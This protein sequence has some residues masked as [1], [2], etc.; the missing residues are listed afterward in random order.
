MVGA[1]L[2]MS[3]VRFI[4]ALFVVLLRSG[5]FMLNSAEHETCHANIS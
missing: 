4:V 1:W 5:F 3:V 2:S